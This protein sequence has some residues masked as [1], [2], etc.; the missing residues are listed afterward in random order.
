[1]RADYSSGAT[2]QQLQSP[3]TVR[4]WVDVHPQPPSTFSKEMSS[5]Q[6]A[7]WLRNHPNLTGTDYKEDISK[8]RGT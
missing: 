3:P 7:Q 4:P 8:L 1:M 2:V 6:L 5:E